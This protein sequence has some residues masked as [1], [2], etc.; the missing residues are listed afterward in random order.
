MPKLN[1]KL[2]DRLI[3]T[4]FKH[5]D[6]K[7]ECGGGVALAPVGTLMEVNPLKSP[8]HISGA[9]WRSISEAQLSGLSK[10]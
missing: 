5:G 10:R 8:R 9:L 6:A 2:S 7:E 3:S 4:A 1:A